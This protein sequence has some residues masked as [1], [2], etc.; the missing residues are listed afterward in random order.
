MDRT[1]FDEILYARASAATLWLARLIDPISGD[2][3][4]LGHNDGTRLFPLSSDDYRDFRPTLQLASNVFDARSYLPPGS[5]DR[6]L[7]FFGVERHAESIVQAHVSPES[8]YVCLRARP[9]VWALLRVPR[10]E[11]R[12]AHADGLHLDLWVRGDNVLLDSGTYSYAASASERDYFGATGAHNTVEFDDED[13]MPRIG[14]FLFARWLTGTL[15]SVDDDHSATAEYSDWRSRR[16]LRRV[17]LNSDWCRVEDHLSGRWR[18]ATLRW[19]VPFDHWTINGT[20]VSNGKV[21]ISLA[22]GAGSVI[23]LAH[24]WES[25]YYMEKAPI[26]VIEVCLPKAVSS[27]TTTIR[28]AASKTG[29]R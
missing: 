10:Y 11:F 9:D 14:R 17:D 29:P 16:H 24:G 23:K 6:P 2:A 18:K 8:S 3:P 7:E 21:E 15:L 12:P 28:F 13:Q 27:V 26:T 22:T 19:R 1:P 25:R 20:V 4:N 5:W